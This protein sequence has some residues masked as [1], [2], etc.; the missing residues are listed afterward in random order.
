V[1]VPV[2][3]KLG[4]TLTIHQDGTE[5]HHH[6]TKA[7]VYDRFGLYCESQTRSFS[8]SELEM[9]H[10]QFYDIF[11]GP[12]RRDLYIWHTEDW[13]WCRG[14]LSRQH[15]K[16]HVY[17]NAIYGVLAGG[18]GEFVTTRFGGI[19]LDL[20]SKGDLSVFLGQLRVLAER[21]HG[22]DGWHF[23]VE[24]QNAGGL[25]LIQVVP[26]TLLATSSTNLRKILRELDA[27]H[28]DLTK[29]AESAGMKT[30]AELEIYPDLSC[31]FRLPLCQ[32][33]TVLLHKPLP[34]IENKRTKR[35]SVQDVVEYMRWINDPRRE[36]MPAEAIVE[37]VRQRI[38]V[39]RTTPKVQPSTEIVSSSPGTLE[40]TG[41]SEGW[42][43]LR[44]RFNNDW[45]GLV[46][47]LA[48]NGVPD[49]DTVNHV[50][51]ELAKWFYHVEFL[52]L[53]EP[54]RVERTRQAICFLVNSK[55]NG[56]VTRWVTG[57]RDQVVSQI[58]RIIGRVSRLGAQFA[59]RLQSIRRAQD[60]D[61]YHR[62][63]RLEPVIR[64][65][66]DV[67][68]AVSS[69][70]T[71]PSPRS[72]YLSLHFLQDR[73]LLG[74]PLPGQVVEIISQHNGGKKFLR[75][76]TRFINAL[77]HSPGYTRFISYDDLYQMLDPELRRQ[78]APKPTTASR[79]LKVMME[80]AGFVE[81][82][83][84]YQR[85]RHANEYKLTAR[86]IDLLFA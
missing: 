18:K 65:E 42:E 43:T 52:D 62:V 63:L 25:H 81:Q 16:D 57:Q 7:L 17:G 70:T 31:G 21:F 2:I 26:E 66:A 50:A 3:K 10:R 35:K 11:V 47:F 39:P 86:A 15:A 69:N 78:V 24:N 9:A 27:A 32:G 6:G 73:G 67:N 61:L 28:P 85:G 22:Q 64:G 23:Q 54:F 33:R 60:A 34:L 76:A 59:S 14:F 74:K 53:D 41:Q 71:P 84:R 49:H 38:A 36:Y 44:N 45:I 75:C 46:K 79:F 58:D 1:I 77:L 8:P 72:I 68:P 56:Y 82:A 4:R 40:E 80:R 5:E 19:D 55:H 30:I 37:Y 48:E 12:C 29:R 20:H 83:R 13:M 51:Y